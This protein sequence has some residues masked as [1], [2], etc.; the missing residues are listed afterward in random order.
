MSIEAPHL[1]KVHIVASILPFFIVHKPHGSIV[2]ETTALHPVWEARLQHKAGERSGGHSVKIIGW[3]VDNGTAYWLI[4]NSW[5]KDWG[6][7]G[8]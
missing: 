5:S 4:A 3:G 1:M 2:V 6:E 8:K 7:N